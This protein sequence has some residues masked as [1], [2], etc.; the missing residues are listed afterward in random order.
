MNFIQYMARIP[1]IVIIMSDCLNM[2]FAAV[3][4]VLPVWPIYLHGQSRHLIRY[5]P[6]LSY[7]SVFACILIC[8]RCCYV[9]E[10]LL[11]SSISFKIL[12]ICLTSLPQYVKV[13]HFIFCFGSSRVLCFCNCNGSFSIRFAL[14]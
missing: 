2:F 8:F 7:L 11:V 6:L 3:L 1:G 12:V 10:K 5:M 9:S 14:Y 13:A 4:N